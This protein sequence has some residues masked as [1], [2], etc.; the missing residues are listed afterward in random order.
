MPAV[1]RVHGERQV[2]LLNFYT[3]CSLTKKYVLLQNQPAVERVHGERQVHV[4]QLPRQ[5][6]LAVHPIA[7]HTFSK[8]SALVHVLCKDTP[9]STFENVRIRA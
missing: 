3:V 4:R 7:A 8:V 1:E 9:E 5:R 6:Y 2:V